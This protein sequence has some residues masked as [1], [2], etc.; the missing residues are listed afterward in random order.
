MLSDGQFWISQCNQMTG[1]GLNSEHRHRSDAAAMW[2][3]SV[4]VRTAQTVDMLPQSRV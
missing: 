2:D 3:Y 1:L 4:C